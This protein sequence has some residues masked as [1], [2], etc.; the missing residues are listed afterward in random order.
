MPNKRQFKVDLLLILLKNTFSLID[1]DTESLTRDV[2][3]TIGILSLDYVTDIPLKICSICSDFSFN[4]STTL[5][6]NKLGFNSDDWSRIIKYT[7]Q[8]TALIKKDDPTVLTNW[9]YFSSLF[10]SM[11]NDDLDLVNN[12]DNFNKYFRF[13]DINNIFKRFIGQLIKDNYVKEAESIHLMLKFAQVVISNAN[14]GMTAADVA[15]M[16]S[17]TI[18]DGLQ[19]DGIIDSEETNLRKTGI[20]GDE[21]YAKHLRAFTLGLVYVLE[22]PFFANDFSVEI[23]QKYYQEYSANLWVAEKTK[24]KARPEKNYVPTFHFSHLKLSESTA[25]LESSEQNKK[26]SFGIFK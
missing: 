5:I 3:S 16:L 25:L 26:R 14:N 17:V 19:I 22:D 13:A 21:N 10:M 24:S 6:N 7:F 15:L 12:Q 8:H 20:F 1:F 23:Y 11:C 2:H 18:F 9:R 4:V